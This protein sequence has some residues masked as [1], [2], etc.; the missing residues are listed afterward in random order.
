M[1]GV[2]QHNIPGGSGEQM[3]PCLPRKRALLGP[4]PGGIQGR[5]ILL[6]TL[7]AR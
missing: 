1:A 4:D 7:P 3:R 2:M 5:M 6:K